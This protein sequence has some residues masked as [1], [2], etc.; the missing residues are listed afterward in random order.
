MNNIQFKKAI[1]RLE[2]MREKYNHL[3]AEYDEVLKGAMQDSLVKRFEYTLEMAWKSCKRHLSEE[4]YSEVKRMG[5]KTLMRFAG[6]MNLVSDTESW[7]RYFDA[8]NGAHPDDFEVHTDSILAV[9]DD[10][11][12]DVTALYQTICGE[13]WND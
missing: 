11:Y 5:P 2:E 7:N 8:R 6:T 1:V 9:V 13:A 3:P 12:E 10:F 4:G